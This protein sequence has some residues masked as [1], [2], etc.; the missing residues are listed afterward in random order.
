LSRL[1]LSRI[2]YH[3]LW[4]YS[5]A[6]VPKLFPSLGAK[7]LDKLRATFPLAMPDLIRHG[8]GLGHWQASQMTGTNEQLTSI[9]FLSSV[10]LHRKRQ[11]HL[12]F[13]LAI[14]QVLSEI[15]SQTWPV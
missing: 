15:M 5:A 2:L 11:A 14:P 10:P 9:E 8:A 6:I 1:R 4:W 13:E 12:G 7:L 3:G